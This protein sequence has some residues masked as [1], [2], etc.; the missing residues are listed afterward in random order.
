[1]NGFVII[2]NIILFIALFAACYLSL[3]FLKNRGEVETVKDVFYNKIVR[4]DIDKEADMEYLKNVVGEIQKKTIYEKTNNLLYYSGVRFRFYWM[5]PTVFFGILTILTILLAML[6]SRLSINIFISLALV[7]SP[8]FVSYLILSILMALNNKAVEDELMQ[9]M[10]MIGSFSASTDDIIFILEKSASYLGTNLRLAIMSCVSY[11]K[12]SGNTSRALM[13]LS[14]QVEHPQFKR[15][16]SALEL[17]SRSSCDYK[18][19][20][21]DFRERTSDSLS[22]IRKLDAVYKNCKMEVF[23]MLFVGAFVIYMSLGLVADIGGFMTVM[24][25]NPFGK[26][27]LAFFVVVYLVSGWYTIFRLN[28]KFK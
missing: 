19:V 12:L 25:M 28:N 14:D 18:R 6:T 20:V 5:T 4:G 8:L 2:F 24:T 26:L 17:A 1:M 23:S 16:I 15:F 21:D 27:I 9:L 10:N 7:L 22:S 3:N 11:A 13:R